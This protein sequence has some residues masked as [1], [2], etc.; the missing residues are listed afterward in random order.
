MDAEQPVPAERITIAMER[1]R[2][3]EQQ[4]LAG[5]IFRRLSAGENVDDVRPLI[6]QMSQLII[7]QHTPQAE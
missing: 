4:Q 7:R 1:I 3:P 5:E 2:T 6:E